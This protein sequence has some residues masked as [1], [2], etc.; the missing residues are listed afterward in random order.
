M[1]LVLF[2]RSFSALS[3]SYPGASFLSMENR[4]P[5]MLL[6]ASSISRTLRPRSQRSH[7]EKSTEVSERKRERALTS[8]LEPPIFSSVYNISSFAFEAYF[9][10]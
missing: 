3:L 8:E 9:Y 5:G 1:F 6:I 2:I 7:T 10:E 4:Y